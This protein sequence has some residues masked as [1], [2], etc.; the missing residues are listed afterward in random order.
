MLE[1]I[2]KYIK[3]TLYCFYIIIVIPFML[4][5]ELGFTYY[6]IIFFVPPLIVF[7][8]TFKLNDKIRLILYLITFLIC[9]YGF[10]YLAAKG[11]M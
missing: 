3:F 2:I 6:I 5:F 1:K 9:W 4:W 8:I 10:Q 7:L 11:G